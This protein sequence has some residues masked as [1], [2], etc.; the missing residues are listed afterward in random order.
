MRATLRTV[1]TAVQLA[2]AL[3]LGAGM[4]SAQTGRVDTI[5]LPEHPRPDFAR[6]Q[7]LNLNGHWRFAFDSA[8]QGEPML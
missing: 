3:S 4:L 7:W 8:D 2:C 1:R 5:P 6:A